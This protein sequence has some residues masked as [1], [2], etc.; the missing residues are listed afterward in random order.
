M[1][2]IFK[3]FDLRVVIA[4]VTTI[5]CVVALSDFLIFKFTYQAQLEGT[6]NQLKT[7]ASTAAHLIDADK[8]AQVPLSKD[9]MHTQ[10]YDYVDDQLKK[11]RVA[12]PQI[13]YIYTL[14]KVDSSDVWRFIVDAETENI[15]DH[16][17]PGDA[18]DASRFPEMLKGYDEPS[19]DDKIEKDQWGATLSG[20]APIRDS[21]GQPQ[22]ILGVDIDASNVSAIYHHALKVAGVI[23][24]IGILLAIILGL[25]ISNR[26]LGSVNELI[27]GTRYIAD[28]NLHHR[29]QVGGDDEISELAGSFNSM[30]ESLERSRR[31]LMDY[32]YDTVKS[33]VLI[34]EYKDQY[35]LGHSQSVAD[36]SEKIAKRMGIDLKTLDMF[37][38]VTL[39]HDIGK[40]G[41]RDNVLQ[42]PDKLNEEEWQNIKIHAVLGEQI[43]RPILHDP[44]M[45]AV[46]RNHHERQDGKGYPDGMSR[47]QIPL[48]VAIVTVA[49]SYD[50]MTADRPYRKA[51]SQE[52]A[53]E[54]LKEGRGSQFHPDVVDT[55]LEILK[56][57]K[58]S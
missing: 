9:G 53:I 50:A 8:L 32:F 41:V 10:A 15:R 28:G 26:V 46:I 20:Y 29:V 5:A 3:R 42:K 38:R 30:A 57:E 34:L 54:Q 58:K 27:A 17:N 12:N 48:L 24:L 51:M 7:I 56:E 35:T 45:L 16:S 23:L 55:F 33:L 39:L 13:K 49:D 43:L 52:K 21:L 18:Y 40:V 4:L 2:S 1:K 36:Y 22:A 44:Q 14:K 47:Q 6:R 31:H 11:I 37:K 19:A 25:L